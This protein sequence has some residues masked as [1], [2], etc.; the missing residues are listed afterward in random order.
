[1][2]YNIELIIDKPR[3]EVWQAFNDPEKMKFWQTSLTAIKTETRA[4]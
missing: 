2:K 4:E 1:M 3:R